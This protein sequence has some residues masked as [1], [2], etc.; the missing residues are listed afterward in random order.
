MFRV[1]TLEEIERK[2]DL[3][4]EELIKYGFQIENIIS[5]DI[6]EIFRLYDNIFFGGQIV[7][8]LKSKNST[9][10]FKITKGTK[11]AGLCQTAKSPG[12]TRC[13][14]TLSFPAHLYKNLFSKGETSLRVNGINCTDKIFCL[15]MVFEH[16][17]VHLLMQLYNYEARGTGIFSAHGKLFNCMVHA[18]FGHTDFR[19]NLLS[20]DEKHI[21]NKEY[22]NVGDK[23]GYEDRKGVFITGR[24][25]KK[26]PKTA[27][28]IITEPSQY[29]GSKIRVPYSLLRRI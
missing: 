2:R 13:F 22:V 1:Y 14:F 19:H 12:G 5:K 18:Y 21:L 7:E 8:K 17:L 20:G 11:I 24:I 27:V 29:R 26:N 10:N 6:Q 25:L 23:L 4:H 3:I 28:V 9:V 16:E 15:Q